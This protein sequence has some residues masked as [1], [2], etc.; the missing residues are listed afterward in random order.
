MSWHFKFPVYRW[1][2]IA[3]IWAFGPITGGINAQEIPELV[4]KNW[5]SEHLKPETPRLIFTNDVELQLR[6]KLGQDSIT[7]QFYA[8][9]K[10]HADYCLTQP[11]LSY[12]KVGRR[13]L[14][15]SRKALKRLLSLSLVY[16]IEKEELYLKR[17]EAEMLTLCYFPDWNPDHFLDVAEMAAGIALGV[18]WCGQDLSAQ[19]VDTAKRALLE[20]A[21]K[22]GIG[23]T[24][25]N[26]WWDSKH[27]WN[28]VCHGGLAIAA[29]VVF[30]E[31]PDIASYIINRTIE[32]F[33]LGL[34]PYQPEG[35]YNEGPSYWFYATDYLTLAL[36]A[37]ETGL[38]TD[39]GF[40][41][42]PG[43]VRSA[44]FSEVA[45]G[46]SGDYYNY[47]DA[48]KAGY[49]SFMHIGLLSWF[50]N[51]KGF[52]PSNQAVTEALKELPLPEEPKVRF[53]TIY[54]LN[55]VQLKEALPS[56]EF[57]QTWVA[58]G[59]APIVVFQPQNPNGMFLAAKGGSA[60]DNHGNMDAGSFILE[61]QKVRFAIDLGNQDYTEL[62]RTIGVGA[63]WDRSQNSPR[64]GLLTKNNFGH[65]TLTVNSE[66]HLVEG[67]AL[68]SQAKTEH[69]APQ[70]SLDLSP[71]FGAG[72]EGAIRSF[73]RKND[74]EFIIKDNV[75]FSDLTHTLTWQW[76]TD[77]EVK[78]EGAIIYLQKEGKTIEL[79]ILEPERFNIKVENLD[80]PPSKFDKVVPNLKCIKVEMET[81]Q[82]SGQSTTIKVKVTGKE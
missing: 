12:Q 6:K 54:L 28:L 61:W 40:L 5:L 39:F 46:P 44:A 69:P 31:E 65:S 55:Y 51:R 71:V 25:S 56:P 19:V 50:G 30:E 10:A 33:P 14:L 66:K 49:H 70:V 57:E 73:E 9:V 47:F 26:W 20:K 67:R 2:L 23:V 24:N 7:R 59:D 29:M 81:K 43:V 13:L 76:V 60:Y 3:L 38:G 17:L 35:A 64:W 16:R 34:L 62:E 37:F 45:A 82:L 15:L 80:P 27:N 42:T 18:D 4:T 77:A 36:S 41:D 11:P 22:P 58:K 52:R 1:Y 53:N 78:T 21:L 63:L 75:R 48:S 32:K 74:R 68:I 79:H 72:L 8:S